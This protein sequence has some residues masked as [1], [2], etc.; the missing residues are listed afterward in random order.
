MRNDDMAKN[1]AEKKDHL[2]AE[3][4]GFLDDQMAGADKD[5]FA[6]PFLV[7]LQSGS[8]QVKRSNPG[9]IEGA[10]EGMFMNTVNEK[11][12]GVFVFL[13]IAFKRQMIE[14]IPRSEGGGLVAIHSMEDCPKY[15]IKDIDGRQVWEMDNGHEIVDTRMHYVLYSAD[16]AKED[17][18]PAVLSL[19]KTQIKKSKRLMYMLDEQRKKGNIFIFSAGTLGESKDDYTWSGW[20]FKALDVVNDNIDL[21][22]EGI[23]LQKAIKEGTAKTDEDGLDKASSE[24]A[25]DSNNF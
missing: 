8:P 5:S 17:W 16:E 23:R 4:V 15:T 24:T 20:A 14:W 9:Y 19:S 18:A 7:I 13:P 1:V 10:E 6:I 21:I 22:S 3:L 11:L 2:P 12:I 25:E